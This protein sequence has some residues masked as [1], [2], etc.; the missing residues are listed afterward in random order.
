[1][2][3]W[4]IWQPDSKY[5]IQTHNISLHWGGSVSIP[6]LVLISSIFRLKRLSL[7]HLGW[8]CP[9]SQAVFSLWRLSSP[10]GGALGARAVGL[11]G[12]VRWQRSRLAAHQINTA[13]HTCFICM[14]GEPGRP[15]RSWLICHLQSPPRVSPGN[16][17]A[18]AVPH[19]QTV[20]FDGERRYAKRCGAARTKRQ[21][22]SVAAAASTLRTLVTS[23]FFRTFYSR[24]RST[25]LCQKCGACRVAHTTTC[26][27]G[28]HWPEAK[29][30]Q[31]MC[32]ARGTTSHCP[33]VWSQTS[34]KW[35]LQH[36]IAGARAIQTNQR[37]GAVTVN[38]IFWISE[39][40]N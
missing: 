20:L 4:I 17:P 32:K 33:L 28:E 11:F 22:K 38:V 12:T 7:V 6:P 34:L 13:C 40:K 25:T 23:Y 8:F 14:W 10:L 1:M 37:W 35:T 3:K 21:E 2:E 24:H 15:Q 36:C 19:F 26:E 18:E 30:W 16:F 9:Q 29:N 31:T 27:R 39:R 5:D